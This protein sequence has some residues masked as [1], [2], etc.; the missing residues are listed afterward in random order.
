[1]LRCGCGWGL[2]GSARVP[3]VNYL[4]KGSV[5]RRVGSFRVGRL[6]KDLTGPL[7]WP[8]VIGFLQCSML[9]IVRAM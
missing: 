3:S 4:A 5:E 6:G 8:V 9:Y 1:M 2:E 7:P